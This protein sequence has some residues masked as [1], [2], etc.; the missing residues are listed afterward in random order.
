MPVSNK[1]VREVESPRGGEVEWVGV[2]YG[3][4]G[5]GR[6][7]FRPAAK[8]S[9]GVVECGWGVGVAVLSAVVS[10]DGVDERVFIV[11]N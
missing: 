8:S 3:F 11:D 9:N 5:G 7:C 10:R 1:S 4:A 6:A 2:R